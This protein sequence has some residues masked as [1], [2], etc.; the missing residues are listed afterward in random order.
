VKEVPSMA[1]IN[2]DLKDNIFS[3]GGGYFIYAFLDSAGLPLIPTNYADTFSYNKEQYD[4]YMNRLRD[5]I[6]MG[7]D[8][9][10]NCSEQFVPHFSGSVELLSLYLGREG[11]LEEGGREYYKMRAPE[12]IEA[13]RLLLEQGGL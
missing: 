10:I 4:S 3:V 13:R 2:P 7:I 8:K 5:C 12:L 6:M 11:H 9:G 1:E